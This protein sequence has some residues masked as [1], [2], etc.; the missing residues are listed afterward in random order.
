VDEDVFCRTWLTGWT[1][2]V[3]LLITME[4]LFAG[5]FDWFTALNAERATAIGT[6][7][8]ALTAI[9][10]LIAAFRTARSATETLEDARKTR[11]AQ[12]VTDLSRRWDEE[13][14]RES[15]LL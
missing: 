7:V 4:L 8:L 12:L 14:M 11:Y 9:V 13:A 1:V 3:L 6:V 10:A 5:L 15:Q 2:V